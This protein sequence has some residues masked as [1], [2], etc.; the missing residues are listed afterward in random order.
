MER[1]F[2]IGVL[3]LL[4]GAPVHAA[5]TLGTFNFNSSQFGDS[6]IEGDGGAYSAGSWLNVVN[7][8]PGNPAY[9]TGAN[10]DTGICNIGMWAPLAYTI[11]YGTPIVNGTGDDL[12]VVVARYS[13]DSFLMAVSLD[14]VSFGPDVAIS[15]DSAV[16]TGVGQAYF[17]SGGGPWDSILWVHPIDLGTTFGLANGAS[18]AAV[19][20]TAGPDAQL[21][22]IRVAGLTSTVVA[23]PAPGAILLCAMGAGLVGWMRRRR[24]L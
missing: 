5:V 21:D 16:D 4:A 2:T 12:G 23:V 14:G 15:S 24:A 6:L 10:F 17:A 13:Y 3:L 7:A 18:I 11:G 1:L 22:L 20:I 8:D 19:R 9:L